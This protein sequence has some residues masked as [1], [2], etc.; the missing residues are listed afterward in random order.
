MLP[1]INK[2]GFTLIELL[3]VIAVLGILAVAVLS[4]INPIEQIN[5]SKDTGSRSDAE[6]LISASDRYYATKGWYAWMASADPAQSKAIDPMQELKAA[7]D[8]IGS[9]NEA[10]LEKL[11][12]GG[13]AELKLSFVTRIVGGNRH[14]WMFNRGV[15]GDSTYVCFIPQ[16]SSFRDDAWLR[17]TAV[18][19]VPG[20][21]PPGACPAGLT[22]M[23]AATSDKATGCYSCLP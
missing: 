10:P 13:T 22:C 21:F 19:G 12:S 5:R 17:C 2:K 18:G 6:Q 1:A 4:A 9:N 14:L 11:S 23:G 8:P 20:D 16:S 7:D 15:E 3:I